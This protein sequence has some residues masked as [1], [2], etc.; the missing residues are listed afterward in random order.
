MRSYDVC[1]IGS[2]AAGGVMAKEL[3]ENLR[4]LVVRGG[5]SN[6]RAFR[7]VAP[8]RS[9]LMPSHGL[10]NIAGSAKADQVEEWGK[11]TNT[12]NGR[13]G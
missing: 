12:R 9:D 5:R 2:G 1:V 10:I 3:C 4:E 11:T 6:A 8:R 13:D 7:D